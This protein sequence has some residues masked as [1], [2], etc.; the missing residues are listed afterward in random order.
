[1]RRMRLRSVGFIGMS[2]GMGDSFGVPLAGGRPSCSRHS[3]AGHRRDH[4]LGRHRRSQ[5]HRLRRFHPLPHPAQPRAGAVFNFV[6]LVGMTCISPRRGPTP[7]STWSRSPATPTRRCSRFHSR[8]GKAP[9]AG[10]VFCP[11]YQGIPASKS[12]SLIAGVT[13]SAIA[14]NRLAGVVLSSGCSSSTAYCS[15]WWA[16]SSSYDHHQDHRVSLLPRQPPAA[17]R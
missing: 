13:G 10:S 12:H 5:R 2:S 17:T 1:M 3:G 4:Y 14:L 6:G 8:H 16:A 11:G 9:S 7:C 15:R